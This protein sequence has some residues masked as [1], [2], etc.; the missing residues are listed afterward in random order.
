MSAI[1]DTGNAPTVDLSAQPVDSSGTVGSWTN[2]DLSVN[3]TD[4]LNFRWES[5]DATNCTSPDFDTN[6]QPDGFVTGVASPA[7]GTQETFTITCT[8]PNGT[9]DDQI[10][11][12]TSGSAVVG[13]PDLAIT[14]LKFST[15]SASEDAAN[16]EW[17]NVELQMIFG[18]YDTAAVTGPVSYRF[19][20]DYDND[21]SFDETGINA[22]WTG[23]LNDGETTG[24][25]TATIDGVVPGTHRLRAELDPADA[26]TESNEGNNTGERITGLDVPAP[27]LSLTP[28]REVV[29]EGQTAEL[30]F[31]VPVNYLL[32]LRARWWWVN[33]PFNT[34]VAPS[35]SPQTT[36]PL[37]NT[38]EFTLTCTDPAYNQTY[39]TT[40]TVEVVPSLEEI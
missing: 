27:T 37:A 29:R 19:D 39:E 2:N 16:R 32:E 20:V 38:T 30:D 22:S 25:L 11:V 17:D 12:T 8:G 31:S 13:L 14:S 34:P 35:D 28:D 4:T 7:V 21:G 10:A 33:V 36:N 9:A 18:N 15:T 3:E 24:I 26:I 6:N 1:V 40:A 5:E 23:T